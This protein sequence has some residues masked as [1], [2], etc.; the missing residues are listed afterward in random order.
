MTGFS[1]PPGEKASVQGLS[2]VSKVCR[3]SAPIFHSCTFL[4][5][6]SFYYA[7]GF[8]PQRKRTESFAFRSESSAG[9]NSFPESSSIPDYTEPEFPLRH[10][11]KYH[12]SMKTLIPFRTSSRYE[13]STSDHSTDE[14]T[15]LRG[16]ISLLN[17]YSTISDLVGSAVRRLPRTRDDWSI[18]L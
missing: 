12:A 13:R 1:H 17:I 10:G 9:M 6:K 18:M 14:D 5:F 7:F 2:F 4:T 3:V 16:I 15:S 11:K 8:L